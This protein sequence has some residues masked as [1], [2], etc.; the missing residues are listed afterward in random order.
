MI[1]WI[2]ICKM[3]R[4]KVIESTDGKMGEVGSYHQPAIKSHV[5]LVKS[6]YHLCFY[7]FNCKTNGMYYIFSNRLKFKYSVN[8]SFKLQKDRWVLNVE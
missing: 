1:F 3:R 5:T 7:S 8:Q 6:P 4:S 2:S